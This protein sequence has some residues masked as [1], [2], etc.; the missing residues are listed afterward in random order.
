MP[1]IAKKARRREQFSGESIEAPSEAEAPQEQ[2]QPK[3]PFPKTTVLIVS[4]N[5]VDN[6]R[7]CLNALK[8]AQYREWIETIVIDLGSRD[9]CGQIDVDFPA[10]TV[11]RLPRHFGKARARNI[12]TRTATGELMLYL[13]PNVELPPPAVAAMAQAFDRDPEA[14]AV[15]MEP[16]S[17]PDIATLRRWCD[18][19]PPELPAI[20]V[21][22]VFVAG[23]NFFD[24]KRY[25]HF[26]GELELFRQLRIAGK[27]QIVL[28]DLGATIHRQP[29]TDDRPADQA[30]LFAERILGA[31]AYLSKHEGLG[32]GLRF[33][34]GY[35][36]RSIFRFRV[37]SYLVTGQRLDG[38]QGNAFP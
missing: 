33:R 14:G 16:Y 35:L 10:V 25:A 30:L 5:C 20:L 29:P 2:E 27:K 37:F 38:T 9:G 17:L 28:G 8:A 18:T 34:M 22:K 15:L 1:S 36:L 32:V 12:G 24:E 6:L 13:E 26:G 23:M 31:A 3:P 11:M 19:G 4:R 21:R 7:T